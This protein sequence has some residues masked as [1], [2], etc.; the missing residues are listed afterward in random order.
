MHKVLLVPENILID[1]LFDQ[2]TQSRTHMCIVTDENEKTVGVV[3][4]EDIMEE[5]VG[6]I[7]DEQDASFS[8]DDFLKEVEE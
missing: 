7:Y 4:M 8:D 1:D 3:T 6:E 2:M 5:L